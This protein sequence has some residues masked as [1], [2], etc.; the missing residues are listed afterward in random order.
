MSEPL[1]VQPWMD[2]TQSSLKRAELLLAALSFEQ[3]IQMAL[4]ASSEEG[5]AML[6]DFNIPDLVLRD[7]PNGVRGETGVTAFPSAQALAAAFNR[8]L[9]EE[10][11]SAVG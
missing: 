5:K 3:K 4:A 1:G 9:A 7:G 8:A 10:F 2:P 11:G 6:G